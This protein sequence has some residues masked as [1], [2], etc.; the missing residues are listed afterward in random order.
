L[1]RAAEDEGTIVCDR[2]SAHRDLDAN[3]RG[4]ASWVANDGGR[5]YDVSIQTLAHHR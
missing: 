5:K 1:M 4:W 2:R 3:E